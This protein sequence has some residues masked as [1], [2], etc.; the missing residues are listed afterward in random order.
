MGHDSFINTLGLMVSERPRMF[1]LMG[2]H[3]WSLKC[4]LQK[5]IVSV[6]RKTTPQRARADESKETQAALSHFP[7]ATAGETSPRFL[8]RAGKWAYIHESGVDVVAALPVDGDEERQAAVRRQDVHAPVFLMVPGQK[9]DATVF[10]TQCW[11]DHVQGLC[12]RMQTMEKIL[13]STLS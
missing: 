5:K 10:H 3:I 9:R 1:A 13:D 2:K 7:V 11:C 8:P 4:T 6:F 12:D